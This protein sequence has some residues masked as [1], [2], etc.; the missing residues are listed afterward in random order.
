MIFNDIFQYYE[1]THPSEVGH[2]DNGLVSG[3]S[4]GL[5]SGSIDDHQSGHGSESSSKSGSSDDVDIMD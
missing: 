3:S 4:S 5:G 1:L 2:S